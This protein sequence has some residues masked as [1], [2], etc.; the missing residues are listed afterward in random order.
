MKPLTFIILILLHPIHTNAFAC[1]PPPKKSDLYIL[2]AVF[3]L[4]ASPVILL[5]LASQYFFAINENKEQLKISAGIKPPVLP[6]QE[7]SLND[8]LSLIDKELTLLEKTLKNHDCASHIAPTTSP[9]TQHIDDRSKRVIQ[10]KD[11]L[12]ALTKRFN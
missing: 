10:I 3:P 2:G 1:G 8:S 6:K 9:N 11:R 4:T 12:Q 5:A 7:D